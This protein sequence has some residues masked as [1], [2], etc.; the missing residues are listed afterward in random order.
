MLVGRGGH[1]RICAVDLV[2]I[3]SQ[4]K[5]E[6]GRYSQGIAQD[7][8]PENYHGKEVAAIPRVTTK[9]LG[10]DFIVILCFY[11]QQTLLL[12]TYYLELERIQ[13]LSRDHAARWK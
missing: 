1:A 3:S 11:I 9:Q 13:T 6:G 12:L 2:N 4:I 5:R 10:K 8:N 7:P